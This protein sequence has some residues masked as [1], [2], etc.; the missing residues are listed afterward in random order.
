[1]LYVRGF[2]GDLEVTRLARDFLGQ[3]FGRHR[4]INRMRRRRQR[5]AN[6]RRGQPRNRRL[7]GLAQID[8][9]F[10]VF[11]RQVRQRAGQGN[12]QHVTGFGLVTAFDRLQLFAATGDGFR[13]RRSPV[14]R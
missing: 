2:H 11:V 10:F 6:Q 9:H 5:N 1:M 8:V 3:T 7:L 4:Q 13:A 12:R 14:R